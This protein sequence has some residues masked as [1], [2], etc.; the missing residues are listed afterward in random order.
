MGRSLKILEFR[1]LLPE[2]MAKRPID[3]CQLLPVKNRSLL[4][5][6]RPPMFA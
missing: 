4:D 6:A 5:S 1:E 2:I 3:Y